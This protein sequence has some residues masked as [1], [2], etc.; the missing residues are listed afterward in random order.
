MRVHVCGGSPRFMFVLDPISD[1][2]THPNN[3]LCVIR[4]DG[5]GP[6]KLI[7]TP[8]FKNS[9]EWWYP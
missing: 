7:D 3:V 5:T 1:R 9:P 4:S 2:F 6:T 8:D